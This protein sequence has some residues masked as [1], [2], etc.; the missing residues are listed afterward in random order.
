MEL[1]QHAEAP[2]SCC[3]SSGDPQAEEVFQMISSIERAFAAFQG[4]CLEV[5]EQWLSVRPRLVM[6]RA[7]LGH[8]RRGPAL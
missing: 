7:E 6:G 4:Y 2:A 1:F 8:L 3:C 5:R